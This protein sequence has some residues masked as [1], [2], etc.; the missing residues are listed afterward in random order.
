MADIGA[1]APHLRRY[2]RGRRVK[3]ASAGA[4]FAPAHSGQNN[5]MQSRMHM[6]TFSSIVAPPAYQSD[7]LVRKTRPTGRV[8]GDDELHL[9]NS[10]IR[11]R[12]DRSCRECT[13][14]SLRDLAA[15]VR[16]HPRPIRS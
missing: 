10:H 7:T 8:A 1:K 2:I 15:Y 13:H 5:L 6:N 11:I 16:R 9:K 12:S 14:R 4:R 3:A